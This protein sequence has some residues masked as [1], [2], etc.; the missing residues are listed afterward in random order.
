MDRQIKYENSE[1]NWRLKSANTICKA[2]KEVQD[3]PAKLVDLS[4][5]SK[6]LATD[7]APQKFHQRS[8]AS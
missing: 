7:I 1:K 5:R 6:A 4:T 3:W 2:S 8:T